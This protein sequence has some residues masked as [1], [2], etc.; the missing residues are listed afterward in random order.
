MMIALLFTFPIFARAAGTIGF[1]YTQAVDDASWGIH[2][3]YEKERHG[4]GK[5]AGEGQLQSGETYRGDVDIGFTFKLQ[6]IGFRVYS[7][8][9]LKGYTLDGLGR[10]NDIGA[11]IVVPVKGVDVSVGIFGRNGNPFAPRT[12]LGTLTDAGFS[13]ETFDG[14]GLGEIQLAEGLS[15]K[16]G[17]TLNAA[18]KAEFDINRF[19]IEAKGLFEI[20]GE[21]Q[22]VHQG[23]VNI[24]T[25]GHLFGNFGWSVQT[26]IETQVWDGT[27]EYEVTSLCA[28][29]YKW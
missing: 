18:V 17:S 14:L 6:R 4:I 16:D 12:A 27:L 21:A 24:G 19:E 11:D 5:L 1:T 10:T 7:D 8:N 26:E 9:K 15:I 22:K 13:E 28:A 23:I 2:G 29:N 3:D 25:S 20:A